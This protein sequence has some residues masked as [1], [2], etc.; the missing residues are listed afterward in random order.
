MI[1]FLHWLEYVRPCRKELVF[2]AFVTRKLNDDLIFEQLV[3]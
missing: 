1:Q 2:P 3:P